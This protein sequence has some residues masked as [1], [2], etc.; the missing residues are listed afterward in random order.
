VLFWSLRFKV[1]IIFEAT[2]IYHSYDILGARM[3]WK[4]K[5][6]IK[7]V[8]IRASL[9]QPVNIRAPRM[10]WQGA[11][12]RKFENFKMQNEE[13]HNYV[14]YHYDMFPIL[15]W[16]CFRFGHCLHIFV[17]HHV[18]LFKAFY[19]HFTSCCVNS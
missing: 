4:P 3:L 19:F 10:F 14:I 7:F 17:T 5:E 1:T 8:K 9:T 13:C 11:L 2:I 18:F 15:G 12:P 6:S 16:D